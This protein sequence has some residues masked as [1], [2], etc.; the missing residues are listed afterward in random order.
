MLLDTTALRL[1]VF[2][3]SACAISAFVSGCSSDA[4]PNSAN[5]GG[6]PINSPDGG[7]DAANGSDGSAQPD[8]NASGDGGLTCTAT[9]VPGRPSG[10]LGAGFVYAG[11]GVNHPVNNGYAVVQKFITSSGDRN[12]LSLVFTDYPGCGYAEADLGKTDGAFGEIFMMDGPHNAGFT[13]GTYVSSFTGSAD[14]GP[15]EIAETIFITPGFQLPKDTCASSRTVSFGNG[16]LKILELTTT[17]VRGEVDLGGAGQ[18]K[19]TFDL[20]ICNYPARD[21]YPKCGCAP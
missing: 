9:P 20:P 6:P 3:A 16:N 1:V 10:T 4:L 13:T 21:T 15:G 11:L 19:G 5:D 17:H 14:A 18:V 12:I 2:A 8:G 7:T